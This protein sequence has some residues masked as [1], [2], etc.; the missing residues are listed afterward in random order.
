[1]NLPNKTFCILP[2]VSVETSPIGTLRPCCLAEDEIVD[3][4]NNKYTVETAMDTVRG[5]QY[6]QDL[7]QQFI[8]GKRPDTC[9]KCWAVED[10][11][12]KSKREYSI[13]RLEHMGI[14]TDTWN[15][16]AKP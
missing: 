15:T 5:S 13:E 16:D 6:M 7:R 8:D 12:G 11:G 14:D 2:W 9:K 1:M 10:S 3:A 4:D